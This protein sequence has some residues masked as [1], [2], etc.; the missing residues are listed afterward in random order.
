M[1]QQTV[2]PALK[3]IKDEKKLTDIFSK[4]Y[5]RYHDEE[6][7]KAY[8]ITTEKF[9]KLSNELA[10]VLCLQVFADEAMADLK[11]KLY[12]LVRKDMKN[13]ISN[14]EI[15]HRQYMRH[16]EAFGRE[17]TSGILDETDAMC[18]AIRPWVTDFKKAVL[19]QV[20]YQKAKHTE[21]M[22]YALLAEK[23][24]AIA[25][26]Y[27][28]DFIRNKVDDFPPSVKKIASLLDFQPMAKM[29]KTIRK[30]LEEFCGRVELN[31]AVRMNVTLKYLINKVESIETVR[32]HGK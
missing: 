12:G 15:L 24:S 20:I 8:G 28:A 2:A 10:K 19:G 32:R 4:F 16:F 17:N 27:T 7:W 22:V 26:Q 29:M 11:G 23:L 5:L 18:D 21:V 13:Y 31:H 6:K 14:L 25:S 30:K 9:V 3:G 1:I